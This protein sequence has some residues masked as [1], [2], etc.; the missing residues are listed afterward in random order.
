MGGRVFHAVLAVVLM[1]LA[2]KLSLAEDIASLKMSEYDTAVPV[3]L[4]VPYF[5]GRVLGS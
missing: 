5:K 2:A 3:P 1:V 4:L